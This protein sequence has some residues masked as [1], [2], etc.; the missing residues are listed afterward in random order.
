MNISGTKEDIT[1]RKTPSYLPWVP[2]VFFS[3]WGRQCALT[4]PK[5]YFEIKVSRK[6]GCV[7]TCIVFK[8]FETPVW[9]GKQNSL[10]GPA[11][12]E[13]FEKQASGFSVHLALL[14]LAPFLS[15]NLSAFDVA[16][17]KVREIGGDDIV[18]IGNEESSVAPYSKHCQNLLTQIIIRK[19]GMHATRVST[20]FLFLINF[21]SCFPKRSKHTRPIDIKSLALIKLCKGF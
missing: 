2:E 6:G 11:T 18:T 19:S 5:S 3:R 14:S 15:A 4:G 16:G 13:S 21:L 9:N 8:T 20:T 7:L 12:I 17:N 1:K 10:T